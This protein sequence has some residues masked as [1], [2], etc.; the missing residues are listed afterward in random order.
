MTPHVHSCSLSLVFSSLQNDDTM[1]R[2]L[3]ELVAE[4]TAKRRPMRNMRA[5][6]HHSSSLSS[7]SI[8]PIQNLVGR[9]PEQDANR[10]ELTKECAE[11]AI[12]WKRYTLVVWHRAIGCVKG[13]EDPTLIH[14]AGYSWSSSEYP[15]KIWRVFASHVP[16]QSSSSENI[17]EIQYVGSSM[18]QQRRWGLQFAIQK[19]EMRKNGTIFE[20]VEAQI[21]NPNIVIRKSTDL[22]HR[23]IG[24]VVIGEIVRCWITKLLLN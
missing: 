24:Q 17:H 8:N 11:D 5:Y 15:S 21:S 1:S 12:L 18:L 19:L 7:S 9:D 3:P 22:K 2:R 14:T 13:S 20:T 10:G 4:C 23:W 16:N 6:S